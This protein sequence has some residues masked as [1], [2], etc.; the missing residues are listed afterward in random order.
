MKIKLGLLIGVF[1]LVLSTSISANAKNRGYY[2]TSKNSTVARFERAGWSCQP[3]RKK[4]SFRFICRPNKGRTSIAAQSRSQHHSTQPNKTRTIQ[5]VAYV[6]P[7]A[8][9]AISFTEADAQGQFAWAVRGYRVWRRISGHHSGWDIPP[10]VPGLKNQPVENLS[11]GT[12]YKVEKLTWG[13]GQNVIM[14]HGNH[15]CRSAHMA[16]G[17]LINPSTNQIWQKGDFVSKG[18]QLGIM[19]M[20]GRAENIHIHYSCYERDAKSGKPAGLCDPSKYHPELLE[21]LKNRPS[22]IL[23]AKR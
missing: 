18:T 19:D 17:S 3:N 6:R 22:T 5:N 12:I 8:N 7:V 20:T 14:D 11:Q 2:K 21:L 16:I 9:T 10:A 1:L 4:S 13:F 23:A 15:F